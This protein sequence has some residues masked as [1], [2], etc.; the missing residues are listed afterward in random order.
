MFESIPRGGDL[1]LL[2]TVIHDW[3]D[4]LSARILRNCRDAMTAESRLLLIE[5]VVPS[6]N[7]PH[8]SKFMDLNMLVLTHGGRE[9]TRAEYRTLFERG[10]FEHSQLIATPSPMSLLEGVPVG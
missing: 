3:S 10:G 4:D 2:K 9:R 6:G 7:E 1:Y 8:P 5:S